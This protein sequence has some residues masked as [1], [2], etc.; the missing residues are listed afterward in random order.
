MRIAT[1]MTELPPAAHSCSVIDVTPLSEQTFQ[2]ELQFNRGAALA[3]EP[4][5]YLKLELTLE[6]EREP[7]SFFYSI[8]NPMS[9]DCHGR[10]VL[11]I[12]NTGGISHK[13]VSCLQRLKSSGSTVND[14]AK[15]KVKIPMGHAYLQSDLGLPHCLIAAG[16]GISKIKCIAEEILKRA[17]AAQVQMYWS[18]KLATEFYLLEEFKAWSKHYEHFKFTPI[19]AVKNKDWNGRFGAIYEVIQAD[20]PS[21][22]RSQVYL[23]G[24]PAMVYGT[25]DQLKSRGLKEENCYSDVFEFAPRIEK[26]SRLKA[27]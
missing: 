11:F 13:I 26:P 12:Q 22:D 20:C 5:Q 21:L 18:N 27:G 4:G 19:L 16:S 10:L 14:E 15:V 2:V 24:S 17:P 23:C 1:A 25:M 7:Q 6:G 9:S 3:Y 8:A